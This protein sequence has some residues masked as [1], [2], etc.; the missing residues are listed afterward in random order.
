MLMR[1]DRPSMQIAQLPI[2]QCMHDGDFF[3]P[4]AT[5]TRKVS[6][7]SCMPEHGLYAHGCHTRDSSHMPI[8]GIP[9]VDRCVLPHAATCL[10]PRASRAACSPSPLFPRACSPASLSLKCDRRRFS[11]LQEL[12]QKVC[13]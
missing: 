9:R 4:R 3:A 5:A 1:A 13:P 6:K 2:D 12:M 10:S 7:H 8:D 11:A